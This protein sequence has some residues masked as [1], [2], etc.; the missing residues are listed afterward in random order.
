METTA[1]RAEGTSSMPES[2]FVYEAFKGVGKIG[3]Y[4]HNILTD[5]MYYTGRS[6]AYFRSVCCGWKSSLHEERVAPGKITIRHLVKSD[7]AIDEAEKREFYMNIGRDVVELT[8]SG[9]EGENLT[10]IDLS[11]YK[12]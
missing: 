7:A 11:R 3:G 1:V 2:E 10:I 6:F 12:I 8:K 5:T 4:L 9:I